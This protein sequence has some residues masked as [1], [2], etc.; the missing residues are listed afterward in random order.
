[1]LDFE[2]H[3][4]APSSTTTLART[5]VDTP[6][7][8]TAGNRTWQCATLKQERIGTL[9]EHHVHNFVFTLL[10][11]T[12]YATTTKKYLT[13]FVAIE[14]PLGCS[15]TAVAKGAAGA[16]HYVRLRR[17]R[18]ARPTKP[19]SI[20]SKNI[21]NL[22][23]DLNCVICEAHAACHHG[24]ATLRAAGLHASCA[25]IAIVGNGSQGGE[26]LLW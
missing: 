13:I 25:P 23:I 12:S 11:L 21:L 16:A 17:L 24:G 18:V 26:H 10:S 15:Q 5:R 1:M 6:G 19:D 20:C 22:R 14:I 3:L 4:P 9:Q 2:L 8:I 7:Y